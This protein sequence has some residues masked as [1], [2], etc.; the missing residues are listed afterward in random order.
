[1]NKAPLNQKI[2]PENFFDLFRSD[3]LTS[4][5][6]REAYTHIVFNTYVL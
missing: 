1:M 4:K 2:F 5:G 3:A 6:T